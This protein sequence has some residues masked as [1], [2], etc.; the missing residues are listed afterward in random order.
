MRNI[1]VTNDDGVFVFGLVFINAT[2]VAILVHLDDCVHN[3]VLRTVAQH[4]TKDELGVFKQR[5]VVDLVDG[6]F[7]EPFL[8]LVEDVVGLLVVMVQQFV[9][10]AFGAESA[11]KDT[12]DIGV[13]GSDACDSLVNQFQVVVLW[14][15]ARLIDGAS[16]GL[17]DAF[18]GLAHHL[19]LGV[20]P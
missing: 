11:A 13:F 18:L 19:A 2:K 17:K 8:V 1:L 14:F 15:Q 12:A 6:K 3:V 16:H 20:V 10:S 7:Q 9:N 4:T 5:I